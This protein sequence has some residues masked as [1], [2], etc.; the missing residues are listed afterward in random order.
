MASRSEFLTG[1][2]PLPRRTVW[3]DLS[4]MIRRRKVVGLGLLLFLLVTTAALAAPFLTPYNPL[5]LDVPNRLLPPNQMHPFGTDEFGRDVLS[6][7]LYGARLSL[8]VGGLVTLLAAGAGT[9]VGLVAGTNTRADRILMR[10]MDGLMA[11]PDILLAIALMASLG[12]SARNVVLAL[13]F[14]YTPRVARVVRS[15]VLVTASQEFVDAA[16]AIG[17]DTVRI[18]LKHILAN[19]LSPVIVQSSFIAAYAMLGEAGLSFLGAGIPPQIPTWGGLISEGQVYLRQ[20][21]WISLFPGAGIVLT[22]LSLNLIG[23]ALRDLLDPRLR[24]V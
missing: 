16:H 20:A 18:L 11:F 3:Y 21:P 12:P 13:S 4:R 23:D 2:H 7:T 19:S 5:A 22:V 6:R 1:T 14:V 10:I 24:T 9:F 17:C 15:S 8:V